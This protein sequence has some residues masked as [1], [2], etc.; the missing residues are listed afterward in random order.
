MQDSTYNEFKKIIKEE[1]KNGLRFIIKRDKGG[2][3]VSYF[4]DFPKYWTLEQRNM[5]RKLHIRV[6]EDLQR[7]F[8]I[9]FKK[10]GGDF[11]A[12]LTGK[13]SG[14]GIDPEIEEL[15]APPRGLDLEKGGYKQRYWYETNKEI[16]H[17]LLPGYKYAREWII[18]HIK[19]LEN[20]G[21]TRAELFRVGK[22]S[23]PYGWG[24]AWAVGGKWRTH[25]ALLRINSRTGGIIM[26]YEERGRKIV[27]SS[28]PQPK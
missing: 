27:L 28:H 2:K 12:A 9:S 6:A 7:Q 4:N 20:K 15:N 16:I 22:A 19:E 11:F 8:G 24:L 17:K 26:E 21:W 14:S 13:I 5:I 25:R 3:V 23:Y 10:E 1:K 18:E